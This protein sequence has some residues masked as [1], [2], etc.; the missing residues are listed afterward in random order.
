MPHSLSFQRLYPPKK[1]N[2]NIEILK[3]LKQ[4]KVNI[5][6][7]DVIKQ[8]PSYA[9]FLKDLCT[10]KRMLK[11]QKKIF[12]TK[13][14]SVI[15]QNNAIPKYKDPDSPTIS[16]VIGNFRVEQALL[17]LGVSMNLLPYS[18]Y[19]QLGLGELKPTTITLQLVDHSV[20]ISRG[21]VEDVLVQVDKFCFPVNFIVLDTHHVLNVSSQ[22]PVIL[23]S[24]F[25]PTSNALINCR[26]G[27]PKLSFGNMILELNIFNIYKQPRDD[28]E[29]QEVNLIETLV[30][31]QFNL[32][33]FSNPL[34]A[35]LV[36]S[37][38]LEFNEDSEIAYLYCLLDFV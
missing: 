13:Q 22:I 24:P 26:S 20:Q 1:L 5:L 29:V 23:G 35:Y 14:V 25:L 12:L 11:V 16:C 33:C 3:V 17:N 8:I 30:Q 31:N 38:D 9:K 18:V 34:E 37:Y 15:I 19:E 28:D 32:S 36:N 21:V 27:V 7:L 6:L 2:Q 10:T 4:V